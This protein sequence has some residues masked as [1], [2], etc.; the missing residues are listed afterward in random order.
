MEDKTITQQQTETTSDD[1]PTYT[2]EELVKKLKSIFR[3]HI[4]GRPEL[5]EPYELWYNWNRIKMAMNWMRKSTKFFV[6]SR[7]H[8]KFKSV[9]EYYIVVDQN[10]ADVYKGILRN[11]KRKIDFMLKRVDEAVQKGFWKDVRDGTD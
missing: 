8:E 2:R 3:K 1:F 9:W 4:F 11:T 6:V 7:P 10:D 5:Y